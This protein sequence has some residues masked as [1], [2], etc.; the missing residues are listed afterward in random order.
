MYGEMMRTQCVR[1]RRRSFL[2]I[3]LIGVVLSFAKVSHAG[4]V[5]DSLRGLLRNTRESA[6]FSRALR[7]PPVKGKFTRGADLVRTERVD[8]GVQYTW[9]TDSETSIGIWSGQD[10]R[11]FKYVGDGN[12]QAWHPYTLN[13]RLQLTPGRSPGWFE[14]VRGGQIEQNQYLRY[15]S[16]GRIPIDMTSE[17]VH[18]SMS[19]AQVFYRLVT[20]HEQSWMR[21]RQAITTLFQLQR[22]FRNDRARLNQ[23]NA[24]LNR[25]ARTLEDDGNRITF[26]QVRG[27]DHSAYRDMAGRMDAAADE[28][29]ALAT[30]RSAREIMQARLAASERAAPSSVPAARL[31][32]LGN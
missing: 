5:A 12:F 2:A 6:E 14:A 9:H 20:D 18:D 30:G 24:L 28:A 32:P 10:P 27:Q 23:V 29:E 8:D 22:R 25:I 15:I 7:N 11:F 4:C 17:F 1:I 3:A 21:T 13:R 16:E 26:L 19:H 31:P